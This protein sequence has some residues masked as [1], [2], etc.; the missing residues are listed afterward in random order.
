MVTTPASEYDSVDSPFLLSIGLITLPAGANSVILNLDVAVPTAIT[1]YES[2]VFQ[3]TH[4]PQDNAVYQL[5]ED[6]HTSTMT[7][8][9]VTE[10]CG[11]DY[12]ENTDTV[13]EDDG[14][15]TA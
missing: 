2:V 6:C 15:D 3:L 14:T 11:D 5:D 4:P 7:D 9:N 10:F 1:P 12:S 13:A 8:D